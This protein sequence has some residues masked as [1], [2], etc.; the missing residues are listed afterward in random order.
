MAS[1]QA[2]TAARIEHAHP[3]YRVWA[4]DENWWYASRVNSRARGLSMTVW[5]KDPDELARELADDAAQ[6]DAER[7]KASAPGRVTDRA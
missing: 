4:S 7:R 3:G 6:A 1:T 5:G 2:E